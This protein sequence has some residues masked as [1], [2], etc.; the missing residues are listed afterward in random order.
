[1]Q[2]YHKAE[3]AKAIKK[4]KAALQKERTEKLSRRNPDRL[5]RQVDELKE[6]IE[7][8][9]ATAHNKKVLADLER[10]LAAVR[11]AR[12]A[13]G[14]EDKEPV[15]RKRDDEGGPKGQGEGDWR[16]KR[17]EQR[18]GGGE[19]EGAADDTDSTDSD[20]EDIPL[21]P[22]PLPPLP[23]EKREEAKITYES[24]PVLRDLRKE[25]A[26]FVPVA[27]KRKLEAEKAAAEAKKGELEGYE[28]HPDDDEDNEEEE[29][30]V[31]GQVAEE[32]VAGGTAVST[33]I[34]M[35]GLRSAFV[36][37]INAAPDVDV[38]DEVRKFRVEME[39]VEDDGR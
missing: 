22:G 30:E 18:L 13:M 26:A 3:K 2:A 24:A 37:R 31:E 34:P 12:K 19:K 21:P 1:M 8:G 16:Q 9:H 20:V 5:Q 4:G 23:G 39:E 38:D 17:R 14:I 7:A 35:A 29:E 11:K 33:T 25:A 10:D 27:V 28:G 32:A 15:K 6:A 36:P